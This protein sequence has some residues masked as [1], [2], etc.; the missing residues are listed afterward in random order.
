MITRPLAVIPVYL[1]AFLVL[2]GLFQTEIGVLA[3]KSQCLLQVLSFL[4]RA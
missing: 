3:L 1:Q 4:F 2:S